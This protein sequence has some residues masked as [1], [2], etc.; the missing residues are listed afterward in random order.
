MWPNDEIR[1]IR[2]IAKKRIG[3]SLLSVFGGAAN[4]PGRYFSER[5]IFHSTT[6]LVILHTVCLINVSLSPA[7]CV[8]RSVSVILQVKYFCSDVFRRITRSESD[9]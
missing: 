2:T 7:R 3:L 6:D 9:T 1:A 8:D 5:V 4:N